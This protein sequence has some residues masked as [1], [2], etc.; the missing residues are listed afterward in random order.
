MSIWKIFNVSRRVIRCTVKSLEAAGIKISW[1]AQRY[2]DNSLIVRDKNCIAV[3]SLSITYYRGRNCRVAC[4]LELDYILR[5]DT[6]AFCPLTK[7][8]RQDDL[9]TTVFVYLVT[10]LQRKLMTTWSDITSTRTCSCW[11]W[12]TRG[13]TRIQAATAT[14]TTQV[15]QATPAI[16][17]ILPPQADTT[18][19][20]SS[21]PHHRHICRIHP[22]PIPRTHTRMFTITA[23]REPARTEFRSTP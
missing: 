16:Q 20:S 10:E 8:S 21:C 13:S 11:R 19:P 7:P 18:S 6:A 15:L 5:N 4:Q 2:N 3:C 1:S 9:T 17:A 22:S 23:T 14:R 12:A